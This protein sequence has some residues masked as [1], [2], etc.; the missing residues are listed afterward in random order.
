MVRNPNWDAEA[1]DFRPAYL[2][3]ITDPGGLRGHRPRRRGRS[4]TAKA[5]VN[6]DFAPPPTVLKEAAQASEPGQL[7]ADPSRRQPLHRPEHAGAAVRRHQ[8]PQGGDRELRSRGAAQHARRPAGRR[9]RDPLHPAGNP[10]VRGGRRAR[11]IRSSTS[12]R[13]RRAIRQLAAKYMKKAGF[14]SG[15]CE[16]D[17]DDHDGRRRR[18]ARQGH[19]RGVRRDQLEQLGLQRRLPAG[20]PRR[21]VHAVLQ[22]SRAAARASARTWDGS[23]TSTIRRRCSTSRSTARASIR[24]TTPTGRCSTIPEINKAI[25]EA[26]LVSDPDERAQAWG[27]IDEHGHGAGPGVPWVWDNQ[28]NVQSTD[29]AGVINLFNAELGP[30]VHVAAK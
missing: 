5:Q 23:R 29:V 6:G 10:R 28:P 8:R 21:H 13:T 15:K 24:R 26:G 25:D 7:D 22:R 18:A 17:C 12:S 19:R 16:G 3:S 30:V 27:E 4:S 11:G 20:G 14:E 2:D 1:T 9:R